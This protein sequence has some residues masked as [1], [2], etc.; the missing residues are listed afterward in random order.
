MAVFVAAGC[1]GDGRIEGV[2][3]PPPNMVQAIEAKI[4]RVST[5]IKRR[6][7]MVDVFIKLLP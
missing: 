7:A 2:G 3:V 1:S 5:I 4:N 6:E